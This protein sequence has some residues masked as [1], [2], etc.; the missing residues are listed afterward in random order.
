MFMVCAMFKL[1]F[2]FEYQSMGGAWVR[3]RQRCC[4]KFGIQTQAAV[5]PNWGQRSH[6]A[7]EELAGQR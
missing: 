1:A 2:G 7:L 5:F 3:P 6:S 4:S